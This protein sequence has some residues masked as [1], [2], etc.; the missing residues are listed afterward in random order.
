M[1]SQ[2]AISAI[3]DTF[4]SPTKA[5]NGLKE[6][7]GWSW[8]AITLLFVFGIGAQVIYFNSVDQAYF[9]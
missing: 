4:L 2:N 9:V 1:K 3:G 5:F 7:K 6:A 8:L